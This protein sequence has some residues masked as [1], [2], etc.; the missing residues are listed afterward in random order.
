M[1]KTKTKKDEGVELL[2]DP[3]AIVSKAEEFLNSKRNRNLTLIIGS[4]VAV[5]VAGIFGYKYYISNQNQEAQR[6]MF[7]AVY[8]FEADSLGKALN[9]DGIN[10]G[11]LQIIEEY[12]GT[13]GSNLSNFYA[14][15]TYLKLG[16]Y[17]GAIRYLNDFSSSDYLLQARAYAL[18]GDAYLEL[19]DFSSAISSYN[20]A[21]DYKPNQNFTPIYLKKL[22]IVEELQ[23]NYAGAANAYGRIIN[24]FKESD[25]LQEAKKQKSRLDGLAA[26]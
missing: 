6:E 16:D 14:G 15:V 11:F 20:D 17:E 12:P 24:D 9:G 23:G 8:Y 2:E 13:E 10:Y 7:Q 26:E 21:I 22:A 19:E 4:I 18:I 1:A 3:D 25:L 5:V